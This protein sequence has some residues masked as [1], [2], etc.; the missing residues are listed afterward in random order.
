V[1][2]AKP[3]WGKKESRAMPSWKGEVLAGRP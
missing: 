3:S 1:N 2:R